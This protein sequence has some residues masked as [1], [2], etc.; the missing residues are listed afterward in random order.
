M[1]IKLLAKLAN[2]KIDSKNEKKLSG[3][4]D[5]VLD[6]VSKIQ[7]LKLDRIKATTHTGNL[8]NILRDDYI[9][10]LRVLTQEEALSNAKRVHNGF[11]VVDAILNDNE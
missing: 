2:L 11:F 3:Q 6:L 7:K 4:F 5:S 1:D 8:K 9:D 10:P